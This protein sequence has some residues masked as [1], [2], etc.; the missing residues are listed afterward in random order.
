MARTYETLRQALL[1]AKLEATAGALRDACFAEAR[2]LLDCRPK[3]RLT[4]ARKNDALDAACHYFQRDIGQWFDNPAAQ[5]EPETC[6][7]T[8]RGAVSWAVAKVMRLNN[9]KWE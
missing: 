9:V 3:V 5:I 4:V 2:M 1:A 8:R 7:Y 6:L